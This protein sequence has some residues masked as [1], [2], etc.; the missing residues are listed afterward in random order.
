ME[1][2][3]G[4]VKFTD[5]SPMCY[6]GCDAARFSMFVS[7]EMRAYPC[8]FMTAD[9]KGVVI[10]DNMLEIW[11]TGGLF[12]KM[13]SRFADSRCQECAHVDVCLGGCP[14]FPEINLCFEEEKRNRHLE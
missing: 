7:E 10:E 2:V 6:D 1:L 14:L 11:Q 9:Y 3:S 5:V 8:S 12:T 13:R 4:L